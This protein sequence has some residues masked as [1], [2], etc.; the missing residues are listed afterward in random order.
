MKKR[1]WLVGFL[2][3]FPLVGSWSVVQAQ[4]KSLIWQRYDVN[5]RVQPN[6]DLL[7]EEVQTIQ[8][9]SGVFRFGFAAIPLDRVEQITDV[10]VSEVIDGSEVTYTPNSSSEYGFTTAINS[11]ELEITWYF[12]PTNDSSHTYILRYRVMGGLPVYEEGDQVFWK[13][14]AADHNFPIQA[15]KIS[16]TLPGTF[17]QDQLVIASYGAPATSYFSDTGQVVFE[18]QNIPADQ[19]VEVRVQFPH[20]V[21]QGT[22]PSWQAQ[23]DQIGG[24]TKNQ[25]VGRWE[26]DGSSGVNS[27]EFFPDGTMIWEEYGMYAD[28]PEVKGTY[29]MPQDGLVVMTLPSNNTDTGR[30]EL[31]LTDVQ[32]TD[33]RLSFYF[34]DQQIE[35]NRVET[36][37]VA[38]SGAAVSRSLLV[39]GLVALALVV[40]GVA[41][42]IGRAHR[43]GRK[44]RFRDAKA[45]I[46]RG[47]KA[48]GLAML[49][50]I[51][52]EDPTHEP[53]WIWIAS[54]ID[55]PEK[56]RQCYQRVLALNPNNGAA[57]SGMALLD[58]TQTGTRKC[59]YCAETIKLEAVVC[60]FC[61]RDLRSANRAPQT[62]PAH[63]IAWTAKPTK[64]KSPVTILAIAL[65][66]CCAVLSAGILCSNI[67]KQQSTSPS[68]APEVSSPTDTRDMAVSEWQGVYIG[69]PADDVLRLHPREEVTADA[70]V[71]GTD[72]DG[73]VTRYSYPGA[74]LILARRLG[75]CPQGADVPECYCY[76][77]IEIHLR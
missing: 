4:D 14:I 17:A 37:P 12:P 51:I 35:L 46:E 8:F 2:I 72:S 21:V 38:S 59:P 33:D 76:R 41:F 45:A 15:S 44:A 24:S 26:N 68:N 29:E 77:V 7:V 3:L 10:S 74:Y 71:I 13:A 48:T 39:V 67:P 16:V 62:T 28:N 11:N 53:A 32:V 30:L 65:V 73:L 70:E 58:S 9:T 61:G 56:K 31:A 36:G 18:A 52:R 5:I 66:V 25:I 23:Q 49:A 64:T 63:P 34:I 40:V 1:L 27:L 54:T 60:R 55:D 75:E 20:S 57:R 19:E 50:S 6:S 69:M 42:Y 47:D 43:M 22:A